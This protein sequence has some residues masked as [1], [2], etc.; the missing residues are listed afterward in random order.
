MRFQ[1]GSNKLATELRVVQFWSEIT[2]AILNRTWAARSFDFKF[3]RMISDQIALHSVQLPLYIA[4]T[5][6]P[7]PIQPGVSPGLITTANSP[8]HAL[9]LAQQNRATASRSTVL[10]RDVDK[11]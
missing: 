3:M 7:Y 6:N 8:P 4:H 5:Y 2:L 9:Q 1:N 10:S 11:L